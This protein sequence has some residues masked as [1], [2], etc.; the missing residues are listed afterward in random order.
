MGLEEFRKLL[1]A[2]FRVFKTQ[3]QRKV[4]SSSVGNIISLMPLPTPSNRKK[5]NLSSSLLYNSAMPF[6]PS[7]HCREQNKYS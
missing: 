1:L 4:A 7:S 3:R 6:S 2:L 5:Y